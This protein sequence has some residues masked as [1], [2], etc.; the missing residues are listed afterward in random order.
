M[1]PAGVTFTVIVPAVPL[2]G[3]AP[4]DN[5]PLMVPEPVAVIVRIALPPVHTCVVPLNTPVGCA[6]TVIVAAAELADVHGLS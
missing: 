4:G 1:V 5:V 6:F 3:I 2:K